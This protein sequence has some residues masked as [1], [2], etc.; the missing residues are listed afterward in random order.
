MRAQYSKDQAG[1]AANK[2]CGQRVRLRSFCKGKEPAPLG[3]GSIAFVGLCG[4]GGL[5][6]ASVISDMVGEYLPE[7]V[8]NVF[9]T[10][11]APAPQHAAQTTA[12]PKAVVAPATPS[13]PY[14]PTLADLQLRLETLRSLEKQTKLTTEVLADIRTEKLRLKKSI[15]QWSSSSNI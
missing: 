13:S 3:L 5:Y 1:E 12:V 4:L 9:E 15:R 11:A 2:A 10:A 6:A 7:D 14:S 8:K